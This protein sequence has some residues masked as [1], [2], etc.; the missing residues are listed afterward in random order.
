MM[1]TIKK[2][3]PFILL[4]LPAVVWAQQP[5]HLLCDRSSNPSGLDNASPRLSWNINTDERNWKQSAYQVMV[6]SD[7]ITLANGVA[8]LWNSGKVHSDRIINIAYKGAS[9]RSFMNCWWKVRVW[10]KNGKPSGWSEPAFWKMGVL[11]SSG[12]KAQWIASGLPLKDYQVKLRA[13][14]DFNMI[15]EKEMYKQNDT[16]RATVDPGKKAPAVYVRKEFTSNKKVRK[17]TAYVCGLGLHEL[18]MN[19]Q[20]V[21]DEY[22][23][24]AYTDYQERILYNTYDVTQH[25]K[26]GKNAIGVI[27]GNG[28]YNLIVPHLL[29]YYA[30]DYIDP[31]K[32]RMQVYLE[33]NDGTTGMIATDTS[34]KC[35]TEGPVVYNDILS[36]E[37]YDAGKEM[38]GWD[39]I[40][41]NDRNWI[42]T[43]VAKAPEGILRSQQLYPVKK[44]YTL[45]AVKVEP[46]GRG[47]RFDLG[48]E[49]CGWARI[50]LK[51]KKG[52]SIRVHYPGAGSHTLGRYQTH[53]FILKDSNPQVF[54]P[55]F[56]YNGFRYVEVEG[57]D[58]APSTADVQGI[59]VATA[60]KK[61]GEFTCSNEQFNKLQQVLVRT[62][63]NY[64][65]HIPNDPTREKSG[66][67]QDIQNGFDVNAYNYD[68]AV[69]YRKWQYDHNDICHENGYVSP[70][71]PSRFDGSTINGPWWGGMIIYNVAKLYE[72]YGDTDIVKNSYEYMKRYLGYLGSIAKDNVVEWGLGEWMEPFRADMKDPRPTTTPVALTSTVAYYHFTERMHFFATMLDKPADAAYFNKLAASIRDSYNKRFFHSQTGVYAQGSQAGQLLSLKYGLVPGGK[73]QLVVDRL[74]EFIA[75]RKGHLATGF[76]ATPIL[77]T[78]LS[79]LGLSKEAYGMATKEDYPGWYDMVFK[80]GNS[81]MKENWE[82]GLVQMPSLA[83]PIG[84]WFFYSLAG[85][86]NVPGKP[87]FEEIIIKPDVLDSLTWASGTFQS[88]RGTI[89]SKW[90]KGAG[91]FE[92]AVTIPANT[93][94]LVYLPTGDVAAISESGKSIV[95]NKDIR[96]QKKEQQH[97]ILRIGS[98]TWLFSVIKD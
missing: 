55:R 7:S 81:V 78:T 38:P 86:R 4:L 68:V 63:E 80:R 69:M 11:T 54:E 56:S 85:I 10:D 62:I 20:R 37:T 64:I 61:T 79:Q 59:L 45:P 66:W 21:S 35:T 82:G 27:L 51:G 22:L 88:P 40:N 60:L 18:Y 75:A 48:E 89:V 29:R 43:R 83:G 71:V 76:V 41:F 90:K 28:W 19:G 84:H 73:Q 92:L 34:W 36:G 14:P 58:Y 8:D 98:G 31:P 65:I 94:A 46:Y 30:A 15:P 93:S 16:I 67:N 26:Q 87:A 13:M 96:I 53:Y 6:A 2:T 44:L 25:I 97:T 77:L 74:K 50:K 95:N 49:I 12:W 91:K 17:A 47:Y 72:Y 5:V 52:D 42:S 1:R 24:P 3:L 9:L 23:N 70:V 39:D 32:L 57:L 33:Y